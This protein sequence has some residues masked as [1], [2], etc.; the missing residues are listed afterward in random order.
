MKTKRF[1]CDIIDYE[2]YNDTRIIEAK[3]RKE[4][5]EILEK[6]Y[7]VKRVNHIYCLDDYQ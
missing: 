4:A 6:K 2:G 3:D 5:Y 7:H 1:E